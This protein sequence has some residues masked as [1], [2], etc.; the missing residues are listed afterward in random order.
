MKWYHLGKV[1]YSVLY[2]V[3][4]FLVCRNKDIHFMIEET[5]FILQVRI[6]CQEIREKQ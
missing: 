6:Y 1:K 2:N 3:V 5:F 4:N